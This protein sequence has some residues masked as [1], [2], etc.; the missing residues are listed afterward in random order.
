MDYDRTAKC[1]KCN[2]DDQVIPILFGMP[3][4]EMIEAEQRGE[5]KLGGCC[6]S[7]MEP[8][9]YC[10]RCDYDFP[11]FDSLFERQGEEESDIE[12]RQVPGED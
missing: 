12:G 4:P 7:G 3:G 11:E 5:I 1:P 6:I 8:E 10:K 2:R 9:Y